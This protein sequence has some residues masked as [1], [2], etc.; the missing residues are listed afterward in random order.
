MDFT[1]EKL[2]DKHLK[3]VKRRRERNEPILITNEEIFLG[4]GYH[5]N[6][7]NV[8]KRGLCLF[9]LFSRF[10]YYRSPISLCHRLPKLHIKYEKNAAH[11]SSSS[12]TMMPYFC[13]A[14]SSLW[15]RYLTWSAGEGSLC[16]L[17]A[18]F[19]H[20]AIIINNNASANIFPR[21][22]TRPSRR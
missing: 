17:P 7:L 19:S 11:S 10:S 6:S 5:C 18:G 21:F 14:H 13:I 20:P 2:L 3:N 22:K 15:G 8:S 12:S 4:Q 16:L 9:P 1:T